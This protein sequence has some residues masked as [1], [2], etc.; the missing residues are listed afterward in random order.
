M[1]EG[2]QFNR[3]DNFKQ[4]YQTPEVEKLS[5]AETEVK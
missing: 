3:T 5:G 4:H 2:S 1:Q